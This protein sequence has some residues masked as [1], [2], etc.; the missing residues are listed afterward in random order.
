MLHITRK[1]GEQIIIDDKTVIEITAIWNNKV[2]ISLEFP[3][4]TK[5]MRKELYEKIKMQNMEAS[6]AL[7]TP[8]VLPK[9]HENENNLIKS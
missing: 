5:V 4:T 6:S 1:L 3:P 9:L 7:S 2:R 8:A